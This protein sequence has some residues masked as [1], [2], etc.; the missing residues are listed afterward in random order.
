MKALIAA[1]LAALPAPLAAQVSPF[2]PSPSVLF[3]AA[4]PLAVADTVKKYKGP[5]V[6]E[7]AVIGGLGGLLAGLML[8]RI[9][10]EQSPCACEDPGLDRAVTY[11]LS[12]LVIGAFVGGL[13]A[14]PE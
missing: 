9:V 11:G 3:Q 10:E 6:V 5:T 13:L 14:A 7:G 1:L 4:G 8:S 12:G 2:R